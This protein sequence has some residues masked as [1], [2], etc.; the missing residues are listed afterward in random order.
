MNTAKT[1]RVMRCNKCGLCFPADYAEKWGRVYGVGLGS[2][3]I[4]EGLSSNYQAPC[5]PR[6]EIPQSNAQIMHPLENCRG[7]LSVVDVTEKEY[8]D[9]KAILA[10]E[11]KN[12]NRRVEV[13]RRIQIK[14][15][16]VMKSAIEAL[17]R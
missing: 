15:S 13:M 17:T 11:D 14:K 16:L 5:F 12:M 2:Q 9:N 1:I 3:P 6:G 8:E 7:Q 4:C 10:V